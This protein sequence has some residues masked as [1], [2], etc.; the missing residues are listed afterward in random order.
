MPELL[1]WFR[2]YKIFWLFTCT[3][4]SGLPSIFVYS[5]VFTSA[6]EQ[7]LKQNTELEQAGEDGVT[8]NFCV[9]SWQ[10]LCN[11]IYKLQISSIL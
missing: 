6:F 4:P 2:N 11:L 9:E 1:S 10:D 3:F 8:E 7:A 5:D